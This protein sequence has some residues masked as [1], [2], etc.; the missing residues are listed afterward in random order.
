MPGEKTAL[1]QRAMEM[2]PILLAT[3][4]ERPLKPP[5]R[6]PMVELIMTIL[7]QRTTAANEKLAFTRMWERYGSWEAIRDADLVELTERITPSNFAEAKA[8]NIKATLAKIIAERGEA[9]IDFLDDLPVEDGLSWLLSLPGVGIKTA[10]LVLLFNFSKPIMPVDTHVHRVSLRTGL[11]APKT[12]A[13]KAHILLLEIL[14]SD[15]HILFNFHVTCLRHGQKIC[16]WNAP[17][18]PQCPIKHLCDYYREIYMPGH[19]SAAPI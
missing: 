4:G 9:N 17:K 18:C 10:S 14:P 1:Q 6:E 19:S 12:S 3:Y 13:E 15:P 8:P 5:R 2:Y 7:S 16:T 11:L